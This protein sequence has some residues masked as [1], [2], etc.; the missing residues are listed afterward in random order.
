MALTKHKLVAIL[1]AGLLAVPMAVQAAP[2]LDQA[3]D[4]PFAGFAQIAGE[5]RAQTFTVGITGTLSRFEVQLFGVGATGN[6]VFEIWNTT[7]GEPTAIPGTALASATISFSGVNHTFVGA[8][9]T[10]GISVRAGDVLAIVLKGGAS[11]LAYWDNTGDLYPSG[12]A[13]TTDTADPT[14]PWIQIGGFP[15]SR[16][17]SFRT[18]VDVT[19]ATL[20]QTL[21]DDV[22]GFGP[23]RILE[24]TVAQA[25]VYYT[26]PDIQATCAAMQFFDYEVR[27]IWKLSK[28]TR[29]A[30]SWKITTAQMDDWLGQSGNIQIALACASR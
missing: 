5:Y 28:A 6:A 20:L 17:F 18:Y 3:N 8:D 2:T 12:S 24:K 7:T 11:Q 26:V 27:V 25:Q 30:A 9:L 22:T 29:K 21:H 1:A 4:S 14:G 19:P 15:G 23:A 10:P 16:D 13:F